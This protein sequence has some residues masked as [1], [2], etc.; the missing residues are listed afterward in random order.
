MGLIRIPKHEYYIKEVGRKE[1]RCFCINPAHTDIIILHVYFLQQICDVCAKMPKKMI[2]VKSRIK[3]TASKQNCNS[4]YL[5]IFC[6]CVLMQTGNGASPILISHP[7]THTGLRM[8]SLLSDQFSLLLFVHSGR[9]DLLFSCLVVSLKLFEH[10]TNLQH[11]V[12]YS[13]SRCTRD[14][15]VH[16]WLK[17]L[18]VFVFCFV[19]FL[20]NM[21]FQLP[22]VCS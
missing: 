14:T 20:L 19:F 4:C 21:C 10:L 2:R 6:A 16:F 3:M 13:C 9:K 22:T 15:C 17:G 18:N 1:Q 7:L 5:F 8:S 12:L 11:S